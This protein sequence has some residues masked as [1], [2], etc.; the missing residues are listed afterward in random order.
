LIAALAGEPAAA[1]VEAEL[2]K[3]GASITAVNLAE[4]VDQLVRVARRSVP[5]LDASLSSLAAGGMSVVVVD[6]EMGKLAGELRARHYHRRTTPISLADCVALAASAISAAT[7]ATSDPFL[8]AVARR[9]GVK[10][11][12]LPDTAGIRP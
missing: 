1:E 6:N 10:V 11:L 12:A 8:A 5:D 3:G 4:V 2:R 9:V 7:L